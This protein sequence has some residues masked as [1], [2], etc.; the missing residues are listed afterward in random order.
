MTREEEGLFL[1][2]F[3]GINARHR[4]NP[5][6]SDSQLC[7]VCLFYLTALSNSLFQGQNKRQHRIPYSSLV[8]HQE[9]EF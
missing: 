2:C 8:T 9:V 1:S 7:L 4:L 6:L 5:I 3:P